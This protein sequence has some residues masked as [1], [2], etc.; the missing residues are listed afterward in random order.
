MDKV[1]YYFYTWRMRLEPDQLVTFAT[2]AKRGSL[3][4]AAKDLFK[5]QPAV[6]AQLKK[7]QEAVGEPLYKRHRYGIRLTET[8]E[9]LL[10]FAQTLLRSLEGAR[11]YAADLK[12]GERGHLRVAASTTVAM[13]YLPK[14]LKEFADRHPGVD[15]H[16]LTCNTQEA[17][18]LLREGGADLALIEGPDDA[19]GLEHAVIA[20]DEIVLGVLPTHPLARRKRVNPKDLDGLKVVRREHGSGTRAVVDAALQIHGVTPKT[21]LEAKGVNAIK[22][23]I[24]QG[25]GAGFISRLAVGREVEMGLLVALPIGVKG[26]RRS[27]SLVHPAPSLCSQNARSFIAFIG[28]SKQ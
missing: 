8:G 14:R 20:Q 18:T 2:V 11:Q 25:F 28:Q 4:E 1:I 7:L 10:P 26:L 22:E 3:S 5:S 13:Y 6:S 24:L 17:L 27:L 23:S 16:L 19:E 9:A 15:L 21:V 12:G